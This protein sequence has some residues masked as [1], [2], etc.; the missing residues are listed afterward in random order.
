MKRK[1]QFLLILVILAG[2]FLAQENVVSC[3]NEL[4]ITEP[5]IIRSGRSLTYQNKI[6]YYDS[7]TGPVFSSSG[8]LTLIDCQIIPL[9][10]SVDFIHTF[11]GNVYLENVTVINPGFN[12]TARLID[13]DGSDITLIDS[14]FKGFARADIWNDDDLYISNCQFNVTEKMFFQQLDDS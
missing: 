4:V 8:S 6:I 5:V 2:F 13:A 3:S 14:T 9:R 7:S 12:N 10:D 1:R 11:D